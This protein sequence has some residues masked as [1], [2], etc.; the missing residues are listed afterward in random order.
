MPRRLV[1]CPVCKTDQHIYRDRICNH[2]ADGGLHC[3]GSHLSIKMVGNEAK[4]TVNNGR[5]Y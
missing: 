1:T 5:R 2:T 3:F 4:I